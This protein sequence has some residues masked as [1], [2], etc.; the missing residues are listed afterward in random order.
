MKSFLQDK[1]RIHTQESVNTYATTTEDYEEM[2]ATSYLSVHLQDN[3]V[4]DVT[5]VE[6]YIEMDSY[7][8]KHPSSSTTQ[9][10][11][12]PRQNKA[13]V[14]VKSESIPMKHNECYGTVP[15]PNHIYAIVEHNSICPVPQL[16]E[17]EYEDIV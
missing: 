10:Q 7:K 6:D 1:A 5:A 14:T 13:S 4:T 15:D 3:A 17:V 12:E 2:D 8:I 9:Q 11:Q 16:K